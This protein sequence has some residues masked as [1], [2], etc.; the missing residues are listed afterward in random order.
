MHACVETFSHNMEHNM[1]G[2]TA[3]AVDSQTMQTST[4][5]IEYALFPTKSQQ[6]KLLHGE[7]WQP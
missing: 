4:E 3:N 1:C 5:N 2:H 7:Q 6:V